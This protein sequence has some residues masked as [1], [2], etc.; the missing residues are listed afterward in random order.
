MMCFDFT[1]LTFSALPSL[2]PIIIGLIRVM[3]ITQL[4]SCLAVILIPYWII[5]SIF[6]LFMI[7]I[8]YLVNYFFGN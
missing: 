1:T 7:T 5:K 4:W 2:P 3:F 8:Y 6:S